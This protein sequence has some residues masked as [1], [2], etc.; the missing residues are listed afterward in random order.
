MSWPSWVSP[1]TGRG[2]H[3]PGRRPAA[4]AVL[5]VDDPSQARIAQILWR[6]GPESTCCHGGRSTSRGEALPVRRRRVAGTAQPLSLSH[7]QNPQVLPMGPK[8]REDHLGG[9]V[10]PPAATTSSSTPTAPTGGSEGRPFSGGFKTRARMPGVVHER[11]SGSLPTVQTYD[12]RAAGRDC[13]CRFGQLRLKF[14]PGLDE[15][16][17]LSMDWAIGSVAC[18]EMPFTEEQCADGPS[19]CRGCR[20]RLADVLCGM[21]AWSTQLP[22]NQPS[23]CRWFEPGPSVRDREGLDSEGCARLDRAGAR[24]IRTSR[25]LWRPP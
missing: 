3:P 20:D 17:H 4:L 19:G 11:L 25:F 18:V 23:R 22:E 12:N 5:D 10:L 9:P 14:A 13:G 8:S 6:R 24:A 1:A 2:R 21:W 7:S 15:S 16:A